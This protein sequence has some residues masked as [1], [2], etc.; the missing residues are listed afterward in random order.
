VIAQTI[1]VAPIIAALTR[2]T[3]EDLWVEYQDELA[4]MNVGP[5]RRVKT[6]IWDARFYLVTALL[7]GFGRA[8][9][10]LGA[11]IIVGGNIDG[12]TRTMTT[13][14]RWK[15]P[16]A[17][18]RARDGADFHHHRDQC[19]RLGRAPR[20]RALGGMTMRAPATD[21][22]IT[23]VD[24]GILAGKVA[25][26]DRFH[27]VKTGERGDRLILDDP[28]NVIKA[29]SE[30]TVRFFRESMSNRAPL[31]LDVRQT[32]HDLEAA[33]AFEHQALRLCKLFGSP[34]ICLRRRFVF[35]GAVV[36]LCFP[37]AQ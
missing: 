4:A 20:R 37:P 18:D 30:K 16:K 32:Y 6:L 15:P 24:A 26:G 29:E 33:V 36:S 34:Q 9:A 22:P 7:A 2:Q 19:S 8:A 25:W 27:M 1:L 35:R 31:A 14:T 17:I 13:A 11:I 10:E 12:F 21:L 3:I 5:A 23:F 28:H